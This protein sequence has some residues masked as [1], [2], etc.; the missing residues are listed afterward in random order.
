[1]EDVSLYRAMNSRSRARAFSRRCGIYENCKDASSEIRSCVDSLDEC[2][3]CLEGIKDLI[4]SL[5]VNTPEVESDLD[6]LSSAFDSVCDR[7]PAD[8]NTIM[9]AVNLHYGY[10]PDADC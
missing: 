6:A 3:E 2:R 4:V 8:L 7:V 10:E 9:S 5:G 1:M